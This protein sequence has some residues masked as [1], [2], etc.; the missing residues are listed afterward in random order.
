[1]ENN[2]LIVET[3]VGA[4]FDAQIARTQRA[5]GVGGRLPSGE[6]ALPGNAPRLGS[7]RG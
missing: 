3:A 2:A 1:M 5:W 4:P 6:R 7:L